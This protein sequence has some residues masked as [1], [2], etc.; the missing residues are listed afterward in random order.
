MA[1]TLILRTITQFYTTEVQL[2]EYDP[3]PLNDWANYSLS[4]LQHF[5][6]KDVIKNQDG[7]LE[8]VDPK[9]TAERFPWIPSAIKTTAYFVVALPFALVGTVF[10]LLSLDSQEVCDAI[11]ANRVT[12]DAPKPLRKIN[13]PPHKPNEAHD[14]KKIEENSSSL[15]TRE[16]T[17]PAQPPLSSV[18]LPK[19]FL[20]PEVLRSEAEKTASSSQEQQEG[21]WD[22]LKAQASSILQTAGDTLATPLRAAQ[23]MSLEMAKQALEPWIKS[24]LNK[25]VSFNK[26]LLGCSQQGPETPNLA[27]VAQ[28]IE[29]NKSWQPFGSRNMLIIMMVSASQMGIKLNSQV[30]TEWEYLDAECQILMNSPKLQKYLDEE[31][32][33]D[34]LMNAQ[35]PL[36][37][38]QALTT[39]VPTEQLMQEHSKFFES[40]LEELNKSS[41]D[42][43]KILLLLNLHQDFCT[44]GAL[45]FYFGRLH[46]AQYRFIK[47]VYDEFLSARYFEL[48]MSCLTKLHAAKFSIPSLDNPIAKDLTKEPPKTAPSTTSAI[49]AGKIGMNDLSSMCKYLIAFEERLLQERDIEN[50]P[51]FI[52]SQR[53]DKERY[54]SPFYMRNYFCTIIAHSE[55]YTKLD[56]DD[57]A[58]WERLDQRFEIIMNHETLKSY[59]DEDPPSHWNGQNIKIE[60]ALCQEKFRSNKTNVL[61]KLEQHSEF[62]RVFLQIAE[63]SHDRTKLQASL[64]APEAVSVFSQARQFLAIRRIMKEIIDEAVFNE[65]CKLYLE[66]IKKLRN[67][68]LKITYLKSKDEAAHSQSTP[69]PS[70]SAPELSAEKIH[71]LNTELRKVADFCH[72]LLENISPDGTKGWIDALKSKEEYCFPFH[73]SKTHEEILKTHRSRFEQSQIR[74]WEKLYPKCVAR[75]GE[76]EELK[77]YLDEAPP[78]GSK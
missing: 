47:G 62:F 40:L 2:D 56:P 6:G 10:R 16:T 21:Y 74:K 45:A 9:K 4:F 8:C 28:Y 55:F 73:W 29:R 64:S 24:Q 69:T 35:L 39:K 77:P 20:P 52:E 58:R 75:F 68:D 76:R 18:P 30:L 5:T 38:S 31:H 67:L 44:Q 70:T 72:T 12:L 48:Y 17:P 26:G 14:I 51:Q 19:A 66:C 65:Y 32:P 59:L 43:L 53:Q 11:F 23:E 78:E 71:Q 7:T 61:N 27:A 13:V 22:Y 36:I 50:I 1:A 41:I 3:N 15:L 54:Q 37:K 63:T 46:K 57:L 33:V 25:L 34:P 42:R 60:E 49:P